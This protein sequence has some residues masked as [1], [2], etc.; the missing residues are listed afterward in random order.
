VAVNDSFSRPA[1]STA[2]LNVLANDTD[3]NGHPLTIT[4]VTAPS[5]GGTAI[6]TSNNT[7]ISYTAGTVGTET[8]NYTIS[9]GHGGTATATV[10]VTVTNTPPVAVNDSFSRPAASTATLS[11]LANDS[12]ANGH[13]LT[14]TSVTAPSRGGTATRVTS[15]TQISYTAGTVGTETFNYTISDGHGGT[16]TATVTVNVTNTAPVAA[17]DSFTVQVGQSPVLNVLANDA[18]ANGHALTITAVGTPTAG[19]TAVRS[20]NN[21]RITY[22][23]AAPPGSESFTYTIS[24]GHG[25]TATATVT[26]NK[27]PIP[28]QALNPTLQVGLTGFETTIQT[29]ANLNGNNAT[30]HAF[31]VGSCMAGNGTIQSG[32]QRVRWVNQNTYYYQCEIGWEMQCPYTY[33]IRN[34]YNGALTSGS[35]TAVFQPVAES[36]PPGM[37]CN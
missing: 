20:N 18:D 8:F 5:R 22:T 37:Q 23:A 9:D 19:G 30:I 14:I 36:L 12:D 4:S 25:G 33:T 24:D 13:P 16:A 17:N 29:L 28:I 2:T 3:A 31:S 11:V 34:S 27:T 10:T 6:R 7:R 26:I 21:T 1:A 15:N 32:S 35:G